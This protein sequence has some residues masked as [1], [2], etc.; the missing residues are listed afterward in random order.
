MNS[1]REED[2]TNAA[3]VFAVANTL[4]FLVR[5]L[6]FDPLVQELG[7]RFSGTE[8][9]DALRSSVAEDPKNLEGAVRPYVYL[10]ASR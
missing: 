3:R 2:L 4:L 6:R 1:P 5:K 9:L 10:V 8:L 7:R